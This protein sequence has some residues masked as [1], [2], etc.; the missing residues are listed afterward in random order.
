SQ[1]IDQIASG[2]AQIDLSTQ[3][4]SRYAAEMAEAAQR[5]SRQTGELRQMMVRFQLQNRG[6]KM[7]LN[8]HPGQKKLAAPSA[9]ETGRDRGGDNM[10]D[11]S[12]GQSDW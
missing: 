2:L 8:W 9:P 12:G 11:Y 4:N 6:Q 3:Q 5:L 7:N 1:S 10:L